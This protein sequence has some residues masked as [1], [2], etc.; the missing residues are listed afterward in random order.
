MTPHKTEASP[1]IRSFE[2]RHCGGEMDYTSRSGL[3][4][5]W[6]RRCGAL[7]AN[8]GVHDLSIPTES[9]RFAVPKE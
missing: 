4:F 2:C 9:L 1:C 5:L 6:C 7:E 3:W 8:D